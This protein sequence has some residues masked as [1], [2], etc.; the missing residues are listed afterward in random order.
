MVPAVLREYLIGSRSY[1]SPSRTTIIIS[2]CSVNSRKGGTSSNSF[3]NYKTKF[4]WSKSAFS[5]CHLSEH[6]ATV[7]YVKLLRIKWIIFAHYNSTRCHGL[8]SSQQIPET[9]EK[10]ILLF[11]TFFSSHGFTFCLDCCLVYRIHLRKPNFCTQLYSTLHNEQW[12]NL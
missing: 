7:A 10:V 12:L 9:Q 8:H 11:H 3:T 2:S 1:K 5:H 4:L 6:F